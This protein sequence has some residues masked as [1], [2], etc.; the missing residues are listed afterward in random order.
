MK[1]YKLIFCILFS[2]ASLTALSQKVY[3]VYLQTEGEQTFY[4]K[5]NSVIH[6][7]SA[8]GY[9]ILSKL[10][11]T[12]YNFSV[13][14]PQ[15]KWPEQNFSVSI[16]KK[17]HGYL[18]KNFG[19]KGWGLFDLQ[20]LAVQMAVSGSASI[21]EKKMEENKDVSV[22]TDILS[23]AADD[24]SLKEKP[25]QSKNEEKKAET[26]IQE[27]VSKENSKELAKD[28]IAIK[29]V[30]IIAKQSQPKA[31]EKKV[32]PIIQENISKENSKEKELTK[33]TV[34]LKPVET[35]AKSELIKEEQKVDNQEQPVVKVEEIVTPAEEEYKPTVV[36]KRSE[37]STTE[38]FGLV[39]IDDL[40]KGI[41]DTIRLL[42]PNPKSIVTA[43]KEEP[44][45]EK[46]FLDILPDTIKKKEETVSDV[47]PVVAGN[48][49]E[50]NVL[51]NNCPA[52]A[53]ESDFFKLRKNMAAAEG[54]DNMLT[55]A[56]NYFK[57]KCFTTEQVKNLGLLFLN[58]EVKY[59][60]FD[61]AYAFVTD[62]DK[63]SVLQNEL[64][65]E[66]YINRFKAMLRN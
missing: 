55:E 13:G 19:E 11:D 18:L 58:D 20:T 34:A 30:E 10:R 26:V 7:S 4:V 40:G 60:F 39:F 14:F 49:V 29:P 31:E 35:I 62:I 47:V 51:K 3:F 24:P 12:T 42:I 25:A 8:S 54:D 45:E 64:K 2:L 28:T 16:N 15:N 63:F 46:K 65:E 61:L 36:R 37:S 56:K 59:K 53:E 50:K 32:E 66:Y 48:P 44:K 52:V 17:D 21:E 38:G 6:S 22:F 9:L 41:N 57:T 27:N 5:I 1:K 33:D 23:K 43:I